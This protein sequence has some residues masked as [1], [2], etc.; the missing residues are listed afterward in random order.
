MNQMGTKDSTQTQGNS[1]GGTSAWPMATGTAGGT[2]EKSDTL[3]N[4]SNM[5]SGGN[6]QTQGNSAG[7][8]SAWPQSTGT[9]AS[10]TPDST[11]K[12]NVADNSSKKMKG[13]KKH[14]N[15]KNG[16]PDN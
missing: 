2:M 6:T 5:Q 13:D 14:K 11:Q 16:N 15:K 10:T 1:A 3:T 8:T 9:A 7:G 4:K 12:G